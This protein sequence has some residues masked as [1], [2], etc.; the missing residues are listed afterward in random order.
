MRKRTLQRRLLRSTVVVGRRRGQDREHRTWFDVRLLARSA[1]HVTQHSAEF[2]LIS[3]CLRFVIFSE[4][5]LGAGEEIVGYG[6]GIPADLLLGMRLDQPL[7]LGNRLSQRRFGLI[8]QGISNRVAAQVMQEQSVP[9]SV[10]LSIGVLLQQ[11][12]VP[13]GGFTQRSIGFL[14]QFPARAVKGRLGESIEQTGQFEVCVDDGVGVLGDIRIGLGQLF[15]VSE[16]FPQLIDFEF[17]LLRI[18]LAVEDTQLRQRFR[19]LEQNG[20]VFGMTLSEFTQQS[21]RFAGGIIA[22][23]RARLPVF[24]VSQC[25]RQRQSVAE[26]IG[27]FFP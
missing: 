22:A 3:R 7:P 15:Q 26:V 24:Q 12:F 5:L 19:Q 25:R 14:F 11:C 6:Q 16:C 9:G 4:M 8:E 23:R 2:G 17:Q 10:P 27:V 13:I 18:E 20:W 21:N 1:F